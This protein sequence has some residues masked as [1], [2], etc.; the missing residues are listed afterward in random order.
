MENTK[1]STDAPN[2]DVSRA[3]GADDSRSCATDTRVGGADDSRDK[4]KI[5]P[6]QDYREGTER[7]GG[8]DDSRSMP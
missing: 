7:C 3:G 6:T 1:A 8:P 4:A 5:D 2:A